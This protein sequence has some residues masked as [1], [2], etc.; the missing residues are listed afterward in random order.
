MQVVKTLIVDSH[1][2]FLKGVESV[3]KEIN[4]PKIELIAS[5][6]NGKE[7]VRYFSTQ[8]VD[9]LITD[10]NLPEI[11]G[12]GVLE[13]IRQGNKDI[14]AIVLTMYDH[15]KFIR[16]A[17]KAG[18]DGYILKNKEEKE[19]EECIQQVMLGGKTFMGAGVHVNRVPTFRKKTTSTTRYQNTDGFI[20]RHS[21]TKRELEILQL[22]SQALSNKE[23][24]KTLYISDQTVSVHRKNIMRKL[25]VSNTAG[26][27]KVAYDHSLI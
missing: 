16:A 26:L 24:G 13:Y 20:K 10:L 5:A 11:D 8:A 22:I 12:M 15:P 3:L 2:I 4:N 25:G 1:P 9:L 23:I 6:K 19:L 14:R 18:V 7:A 17:F 21:L 27:I